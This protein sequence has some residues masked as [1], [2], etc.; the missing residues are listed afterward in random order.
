A[1]ELFASVGLETAVQRVG[2]GA[3]V[4][5]RARAARGDAMEN[6]L[7]VFDVEP[8]DR[9][10]QP[11]LRTAALLATLAE[12]VLAARDWAKDVVIV[13]VDGEAGMRAFLRSRF[14]LTPADL[15]SRAIA[16]RTRA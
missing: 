7:L 1:R 6:I 8:R 5:A 13:G 12:T 10:D 4:W 15:G 11:A 2:G 3:N 9:G 16:L 14:E